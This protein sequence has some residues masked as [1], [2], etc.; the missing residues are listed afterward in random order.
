MRKS[1]LLG[2]GLVLIAVA[3]GCGRSGPE[4]A[5]QDQ[6]DVMNDMAAVL[7]GVTDERSAKNAEPKIKQLEERAKAAS[8]R[9]KAMPKEQVAAAVEKHKTALEKATKRLGEAVMKAAMSGGKLNL[10]LPKH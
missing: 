10:G 7:E 8:E 9:M 6:I 4:G 2:L 1:L 3:P 5:V